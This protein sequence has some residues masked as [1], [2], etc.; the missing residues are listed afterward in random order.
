M[1]VGYTYKQK[2][3]GKKYIITSEKGINKLEKVIVN[4]TEQWV[5]MRGQNKECPVIL[6]LHGGPGKPDMSWAIPFQQELE[7]QFVVVR[8]DQRGSG[9][10]FSSTIPKESMNITQFVADTHSVT[11]FLKNKFHKEKIYLIGHSWGSALG[12]LA[13]Q[14]FPKEYEAFIGTGQFVNL[15]AQRKGSYT[16]VLTT[17]TKNKDTKAIQQLQ[18]IGKPSKESINFDYLKELD[19]LVLK[20]G[21]ELYKEKDY[22]KIMKHSFCSPFYS[23]TDFLYAFPRGGLFSSVMIPELLNIN[24][25]EQIKEVKVPTYFFQGRHDYNTTSSVVEKYVKELKAPT[26]KLVWFEQSAH[27]PPF[28]EPEKFQKEVIRLFCQDE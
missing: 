6:F 5:L 8:W 3:K 17:A 15:I 18:K 9:K 11:T 28:E 10:S 20:F 24:L 16:F 12:L 25:S 26:K 21:G 23:L 1:L 14:Q 13:I 2:L 19:G 7:K 27:S 22:G 4:G